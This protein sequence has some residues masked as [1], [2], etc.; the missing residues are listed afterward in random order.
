MGFLQRY[1]GWLPSD[2]HRQTSCCLYDSVFAGSPHSW[3]ATRKVDQKC[4]WKLPST[5]LW[6]WS[7]WRCRYCSGSISGTKQNV[8]IA[9]V[10]NSVCILPFQPPSSLAHI[11]F[12]TLLDKLRLKY[13]FEK[14]QRSHL[15]IHE[16]LHSMVS[17]M[18]QFEYLMLELC[19]SP[20][21]FRHLPPV[22][23]HTH[24]Q[25]VIYWITVY[26]PASLHVFI[27]RNVP[28]VN[29]LSCMRLR[30]KLCSMS[31]PNSYLWHFRMTAR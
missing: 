21:C 24:F 7:T 9:G 23:G 19:V 3:T 27:L 12:L 22:G 5:L 6:N 15:R 26:I 31:S 11:Y 8:C 18:L 28:L 30:N 2:I 10:F 4:S 20:V 17:C 29:H 13:K 25:V 16:M 14:Q 1:S